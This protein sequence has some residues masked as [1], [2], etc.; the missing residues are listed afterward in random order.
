LDAGKADV[1]IMGN[2][3]EAPLIQ[4]PLRDPGVR[5]VSLPR[6]KTLTRRFPVL[7]RLELSNGALADS[8]GAWHFDQRRG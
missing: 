8:D 5:L 4:N 3:P 1:P 2:V 6:V 7:T